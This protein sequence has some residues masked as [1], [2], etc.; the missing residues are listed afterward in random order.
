MPK[1]T[2]RLRSHPIYGVWSNMLYMCSNPN[3]ANYANYGG[4]GIKVCDRWLSSDLFFEDMLLTWK[5]GLQLDRI[6]NDG[7]YEPSNCQWNTRSA[8]T[9]N[10]RISVDQQSRYD[11]VIWNS[12]TNSWMVNFRRSHFAYDKD[13][14]I[15]LDKIMYFV[16]KDKAH[17]NLPD[18]L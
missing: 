16:D 5:E 11:G 9:K 13:A 15:F 18:C 17:I 2:H 1:K 6:N 4:R 7:D 10:R 14:A 8:N 12:Q 3:A